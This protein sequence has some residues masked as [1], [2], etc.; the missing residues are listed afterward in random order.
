MRLRIW[1]L[2]VVGVAIA[3]V[4]SW[5]SYSVVDDRSTTAGTVLLLAS[6][7]AGMFLT[8]LSTKIKA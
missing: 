3:A 6:L 8:H 2:R 7:A 5:L 1:A 4:G